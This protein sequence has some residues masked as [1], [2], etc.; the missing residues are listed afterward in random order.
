MTW[1]SDAILTRT[2][3]LKDLFGKDS[4]V[5]LI[6]FTVWFHWARLCSSLKWRHAC[7][8]LWTSSD[9]VYFISLPCILCFNHKWYT[10]LSCSVDPQR[11]A[12]GDLKNWTLYALVSE[13][14]STWLLSASAMNGLGAHSRRR[15]RTL[16]S[17]SRRVAVTQTSPVEPRG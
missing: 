2:V 4:V 1:R 8:L 17:Y 7:L 5:S 3:S 16:H 9:Y 15:A 11:S 14:S 13:C 12:Q 6:C 10:W